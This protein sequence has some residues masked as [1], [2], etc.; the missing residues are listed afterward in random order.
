[1]KDK[2]ENIEKAFFNWLVFNRHKIIFLF[3]V[4]IVI[5]FISL[6][7]YINLV[8]PK[9][10]IPVIIFIAAIF[11]LDLNIEKIIKLG[12]FIFIIAL[13]FYLIDRL[14]TAEILANYIY[15]ILL[16]AVI[17]SIFSLNNK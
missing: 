13:F 9:E 1:M 17:R 8:I 3:F 2:L 6:L 14:E 15:L 11:I 7:P 5:I 4:T 12:L 16:T 10:L